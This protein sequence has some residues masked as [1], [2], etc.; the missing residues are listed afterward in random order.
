MPPVATAAPPEP[1]GLPPAF[2][3]PVAP[4][5]TDAPPLPMLPLLD[6]TPPLP[7]CPSEPALP[8]AL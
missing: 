1:I 6:T 4:P 3:F 8:P 2:P 7:M 5:V